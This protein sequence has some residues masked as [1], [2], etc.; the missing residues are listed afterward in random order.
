[1]KTHSIA[2]AVPG[3]S[4]DNSVALQSRAGMAAQACSRS[5]RRRV[6][7]ML[8]LACRVLGIKRRKGSGLA[9]LGAASVVLMSGTPAH[10]ANGIHINA[11][12]AGPC[13][14]IND[15]R[16]W[17]F[18]VSNA[19]HMR[20]EFNTR[21]TS[22]ACNSGY[23]GQR[24]SVL[25]Y[26]P[27]TVSGVGA[28]SLMLGGELAV[29][30]GFIKLGDA[31][32]GQRIGNVN[33]TAAALGLAIGDGAIAQGGGL[34]LGS[35]ARATGMVAA[36][37]LGNK[38]TAAGNY[39]TIVGT[40][41]RVSV[42]DAPT[43]L[44]NTHYMTVLGPSAV[45]VGESST[46]A[47]RFSQSPGTRSLAL[48]R[49][50]VSRQ[51]DS[52]A[53]GMEAAVSHSQS[54][55]LGAGSGTSDYQTAQPVV[56]NGVS[57]SFD[58]TGLAGVVSAG[59]AFRNRQFVNVA[60]GMVNAQSR[61]AVT[62]AQLFA[63]YD[64]I[65][66]LG[67]SDRRQQT[68][69]DD[70]AAGLRAAR[71][72]QAAMT[73]S[74]AQAIGGGASVGADGLIVM[75]NQQAGG[76]G[77]GQGQAATVVGSLVAVDRRLKTEDVRL[78]EVFDQAFD[79]HGKTSVAEDQ[80]RGI[81]PGE[82]VAA[83]IDDVKRNTLAWDA[84]QGVYNATNGTGA[85]HRIASLAA[86]QAA[87]D[88][89][90]KGQLDRA[91]A[92]LKAHGEGLLRERDG[93]L[94]VGAGSAA[95]T[96]NLAGNTP[97]RDAQGNPVL[98]A[99]GNPVMTPVNRTLTGVADGVNV[100]DVANKRQLD[101]VA[102]AVTVAQA[103]ATAA[104][105]AADAA[106]DAAAGAQPVATAAQ[107]AA[108]AAQRSADAAQI[109]AAGA[110]QSAGAADAKLAGIGDNETV[111]GRIAQ[112]AQ[113]ATDAAGRAAGQSLADALG[114]GATMGA[115]GKLGAPAYGVSQIGA[116]GQVAAQ[117]QTA[118]NVGDA[119]SALD[120]NVI[121]VN[122]RVL[123]QDAKVNGLTQDLSDLRSDS[124]QWNEQAGA[125][126]AAH[127]GDAPN[128][129]VNVAAGQAAT[130]AVNKGQLENVTQAVTAAQDAASGAGTA[131][132]AA[133]GVASA[134][135]QAARAAR[136]T[137]SGARLAAEAAQVTAAGARQAAL[138]SE[139]AATGAQQ[140]AQAGRAAAVD[141]RQA[142]DAAQ[143]AATGARQVADAA[144]GTAT[145]AQQAATAAQAAATRAQ[146]T[147][148]AAQVAAAGAQ[149]AAD[150]ANAKLAGI[151]DGETVAGRI[152]Q[153]ARDAADAAGRA[154]G[155][156]LADAL[157][158][159]AT[160]GADGTPGAPA[161][162]VSQIGTDGQVAAQ[163]Q[164]ATNVGDALSALDA[165]VIKVNDRVLAQEAQ[166][167]GLT[168]DLA[169]LRSDS[170]RWDQGAGAF[171]AAHGAD[172]PNR[173]VNLAAGQAATDAVNKGQLDQAVADLKAQGAGLLQ[174]RDG[175]LLAGADSTAK[176]VNL[177]GGTPERDADGNP[178]LDAGGNPVMAPVNR[179]VTGV[180]D[181]VNG[182][183]AVNKGQ[184][185][186]VAQTASAAQDAAVT[187][188]QRADAAHVTATGAQQSATAAQNAASIAQQSAATAQGAASGAQ[189]AA[190]AANAKLVGI[191]D[192]ET[193]AGRI[194]Q[195][196]HAATEA[197]GRAAGQSLADAL[198]GGSVLGADGK[199]SAPAYAIS[200]FDADGRIA[201]Q[202]Q[203][204]NNVGDALAAIDANVIKV[205]D[206]V[207]AQDAKVGG[208]TQDLSDLRS[209][210][211]LWDEGA[212]A[213]SAAHGADAPNRIVNVA[214]GQAATDAVNKGQL[215]TVT[216][217]ADEAQAVAADA[218]QVAEAAQGI[219][220]DG[221]RGAEA[222]QRTARGAQHSAG[223]ANAKLAGIGD[224]ETVAGR[225]DEAARAAGQ[226][227]ADALGGGA[228]VRD[229]GTVQGPVL[230]V[231]A[232]GSAGG[233]NAQPSPAGN[234]ADAI[235]TIDG[236]VA[237][238][239]DNVNRVGADAL[240]MRD[241]LNAGQLGLVQQDPVT[242]DIT[243]AKQTDGTRITLEGASG[244]RT[245]SGV[246]AG[247]ISG[248]STEAVVGSQLFTVN[249]DLLKNSHAVGSLEALT[250]Q[251]GAALGSLSALVDSG[252]V[253]LTRHDPSSNTV[254]LAADRGGDTVDVS[255]KDGTRQVTGLQDGRIQA[256]STDAVTGGQMN[257]V[258]ERINRLDVR[259][260]SVAVDSRGDGSDR[261][262]V[263]PGSRGVAMGAN[264]QATGA[265]SI[266]TG[267]GATARGADGSAMGAGAQ[268]Q[269]PAS[270]AV[271]ANAKA[272]A[273]GSVAIG[274][275][276]QA[277]R[278]NTV[279]VG[280]AGAGRQITHVAPATYGADA[281]NLRQ[282]IDL[283]RRDANQARAQ[284]KRHTDS[285]VS[286]LRRDNNA[287]I[288]SAMAMAT[289]PSTATPGKSMFALG[290][291][292]Y[293]SQSAVAL[294]VS[295]R[296]G[297][298]T[299]VYRASLS[300]TTG[301]QTGASIGLT[302]AW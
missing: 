302:Y 298:G 239:N 43:R 147:A 197:A 198:G 1:M 46:A 87:T 301:G 69:L 205:N 129:I 19:E 112:A 103:A 159:G 230:A 34:G 216:L 238:V 116:D 259:G 171:S 5:L 176:T 145:G 232:I 165:N 136:D 12:A 122:D 277:T 58:S 106:Q 214:P 155:Q 296:S 53:L 189:Q 31:T 121:K 83:R 195:A 23:T 202:D 240:T 20:A 92:D 258:T 56:L 257:A 74:T 236:S 99:G 209:D 243:V 282:A 42:L 287:G 67:T 192:G 153:A 50:T 226:S 132:E 114:G 233:A 295:A 18:P 95:T 268:A 264:A 229:D 89:V 290:A 47:G 179:T 33:T 91:A 250:S 66:V 211:L 190:N 22:E 27:S 52:V 137:V 105:R 252:N 38:T 16:P 288:A 98:D 267:S 265:N 26:R 244:A 115:D 275:G 175:Q 60:H 101:G 235:K 217:T 109:A 170:L 35:L 94:Q 168:Q 278:A 237:A 247:E 148:G 283:S 55:A 199:P 222:A 193:V 6:S 178:V 201:A 174:E 269:A 203:T 180:A 279:S 113:A 57:Y 225:I 286:Q 261:A 126:S 81:G 294:G 173:I 44:S 110:Q 119:L 107:G 63:G 36:T 248:T 181:G 260:A 223:D 206:R 154:A 138:S 284:A 130:D 246:K 184:L 266:A 2:A 251:Q 141:A 13:V 297:S 127:G 9:L 32:T 281:V 185:D 3:V 255:G 219:A 262:V 71:A 210:S 73:A 273:A 256:G 90:N 271:G 172:A 100:H 14:G 108:T 234:V 28:T 133:Q 59:T 186:G 156:S 97:Q 144:Q 61:D 111:A 76:Q 177:A 88:A 182:N 68:A 11:S 272:S 41:S 231:T 54:V 150:A 124:L 4:L 139:R 149:Q 48:G 228:A 79:A 270:T 25:F 84:A 65:N 82:T 299:W 191:G 62:G 241:Q 166:A 49:A 39:S 75:P 274:Q 78:G 123:A 162:G 221:Q 158:G 215:D 227:L 187:A 289:L 8:R 300:G 40:A 70:N 292:T 51:T 143:S 160:V 77:E 10:A 263:R 167:A 163:A 131:A 280:S 183:D 200:Q 7:A 151:G 224:G 208:L 242:H 212:Q 293:D 86:G 253:G 161:Y 117:S 140:A 118:T 80:L 104:Q 164:T 194:E 125:F 29:N 220:I 135:D 245:L 21:D 249:Q 134:A 204:A 285:R 85:Q 93:Q 96:V 102:Q 15:P 72:G 146:G 276:A 218:Q 37:A 188:Q 213:F 128:R 169:D 30:G 142:A 157:G 24:D 207:L 64:A 291:A 254:S 196:A 45:A 120:A 17:F 152:A